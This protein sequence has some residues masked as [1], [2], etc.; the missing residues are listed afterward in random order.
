[1]T[2]VKSKGH[3]PAAAKVLYTSA[4]FK[5]RRAYAEELSV[6]LVHPLGQVR[7]GDP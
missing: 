4:L 3:E 2:C 1:M 6:P 5:K 7:T